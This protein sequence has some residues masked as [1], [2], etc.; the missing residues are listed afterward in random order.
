M[1]AAKK[2]SAMSVQELLDAAQEEAAS[3]TY[4]PGSVLTVT[5]P[6]YNRAAL[7]LQAAQ[8]QATQGV[9]WTLENRIAP[10]IGMQP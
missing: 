3:Y 5:P 2:W 6:A 1:S 8:I 4:V 10:S 7:L 9:S